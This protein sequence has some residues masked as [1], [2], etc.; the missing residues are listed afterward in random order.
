LGENPTLAGI[1]HCNRLEQILARAECSDSDISEGV[2]FS[3]SG[4]LISGTMTNIFLVKGAA[5]RTPCIDVCGVAGIMRCVVLREAER[6]G[7]ATQECALY[8]EDLSTAE[9]VFLTNARIGIW[10]VRSIDQRS[11]VPGPVTRR[12]QTLLTPLLEDPPDA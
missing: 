11:L 9:E 5:L 12:L 4:K 2:L 8:A 6:A 7:I 10:P 1:K 3:S